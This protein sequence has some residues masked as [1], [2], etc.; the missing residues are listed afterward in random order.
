MGIGRS[1]KSD[2]QQIVALVVALDE[3]FTMNHEDRIAEYDRRITT[4]TKATEG[5]PGVSPDTYWSGDSFYGSFLTIKVDADTLGKDA[6]QIKAE[7]F[8]GSPSVMLQAPDAETFRVFVY[9]LDEGDAETIA[10]RLEEV[11]SS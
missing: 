11:F 3:W 5:V 4:I 1:M 6:Q 2:R 10:G 7:M 8:E 9:T